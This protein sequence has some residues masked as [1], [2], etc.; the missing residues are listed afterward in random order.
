[1]ENLQYGII[2]GRDLLQSTNPVIDWVACSLQLSM[3]DNVHT[4]LAFPV[5]N[6]ANRTL[7]SLKQV[8]AEIKCGCPA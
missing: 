7:S 5:N 2:L 1:M 3:G 8:L 4:V 6:I